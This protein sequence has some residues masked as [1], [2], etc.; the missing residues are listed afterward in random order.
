MW[1]VRGGV[2]LL[3]L[4]GREGRGCERVLCLGWYAEIEQGLQFV[5]GLVQAH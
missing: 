2:H 3:G 4:G 1:L 5:V